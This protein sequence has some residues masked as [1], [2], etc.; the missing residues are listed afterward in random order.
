MIAN[1]FKNHDNILFPYTMEM[2]VSIREILSNVCTT[3]FQVFGMNPS[4]RLTKSVTCW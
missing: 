4:N 3:Q 1:K 2:S